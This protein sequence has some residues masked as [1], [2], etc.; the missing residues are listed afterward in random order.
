MNEAVYDILLL[1][2]NYVR[3]VVHYVFNCCDSGFVNVN[4]GLGDYGR[5]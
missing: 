2:M 3:K 4:I 1:Y 5:R